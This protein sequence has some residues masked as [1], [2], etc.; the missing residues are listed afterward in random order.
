VPKGNTRTLKHGLHTY[1]RI[2]SGAKLDGRTSLFKVLR[3]K[4]QEL[5]TALGGDVSPQQQLLISD[6][7][8]T[9]LYVS[10]L[11]EYLMNLDGGIIKNGK[12]ISVVETRTSLPSHLRRD[13]EAL[14]L[15]RQQREQTLEQL[16]GEDD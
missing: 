6:A 15:H 4:E 16:L 3:E 11:D 12:V 13:L 9:Q 2:L 7:V 5:I 14:G 1:R 8:K 10:V